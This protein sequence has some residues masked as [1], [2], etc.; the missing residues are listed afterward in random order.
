MPSFWRTSY[1]VAR[2][3]HEIGLRMALGAGPSD[4]LRM[5]VQKGMHIAA[6]GIAIGL[7]GAVGN[8][9]RIVTSCLPRIRSDHHIAVCYLHQSGDKL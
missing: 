5:V 4:V 7:A 2:R 9:R 1:S 8:A 3:T 6:F